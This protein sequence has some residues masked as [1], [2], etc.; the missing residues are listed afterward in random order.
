MSKY[1]VNKNN[2]HEVHKDGCS[3]MP[4]SENRIYLWE[5]DSCKDAVKEAKKT[6]S[7]ANWCYYCSNDCH[8]T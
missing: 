8:T 5:F 6:Y 4:L 7:S 3:Y 1:Y 2:D